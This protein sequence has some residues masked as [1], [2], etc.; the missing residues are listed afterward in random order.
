[1]VRELGLD[2]AKAGLVASALVHATRTVAAN[3]I[4]VKFFIPESLVFSAEWAA[5]GR[6]AASSAAR[7][8]GRPERWPSPLLGKR[9]P[10]GP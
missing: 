2:A 9:Y 10:E 3:R 5:I 7:V 4:G 6:A 1:M 8:R